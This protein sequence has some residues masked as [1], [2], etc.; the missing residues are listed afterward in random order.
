MKKLLKI[1][2]WVAGIFVVL[3]ILVIVGFKL[4][5]PVEKAKAMAIERA[6]A[7]MGREITIEGID[8]SIWGGLGIQLVEVAVANPPEFEDGKFL[9]ADNVDLKLKFWPLLSG[10]FRIDRLI[11]N[12]PEV[13]MHK[14]ADGSNNYEFKA[15][16][17]AAPPEITEQL[18]PEAKTAGVAVSF[19][20]FEIA[21]G[22]VEFVDDSSEFAVKLVGLDL[23]TTVSNPG[24]GQYL[25]TG[26]LRADSL[27][28]T[29]KTPL[30][31]LAINL[32][33]DAEYDLNKSF[34]NLKSADLKL[35]KLLLKLKG[36]LSHPK[37]AMTVRGNIKSDRIAV[38]D[39]FEFL[40]PK[41]L[42]LVKD[43]RIEGSFALNTDVDYNENRPE[44][45]GYAGTATVTNLKLSQKDIA[46]ELQFEKALIDFKPNNL[47]LNIEKGT[48]DSKPLKGH[49]V[50]ENFA[51]PYVNGELAGSLN[52]AFVQPFLPENMS[53]KITGQ[54]EVDLKVT[55]RTKDYENLDFSG[56]L[57][58]TGG[59]YNSP[60]MPEPLD[61]FNL[62]AYLDRKTTRINKMSGT[63][64]SGSFSFTGRI[65]DLMPYVMADSI[66]AKKIFPGIDG[67]FD[68]KLDLALLTR[69]L[70]PKGNPQLKG[71]MAI[72]LNLLGTIQKP[73][74]IIKRGEI[75][76]ADASYNDSLLPEPLT[77]L[78]AVMKIAPDTIT[79]EKLSAKFVSS[80]ATFSGKLIEPFPYLLPMKNLDRSKL[81]KPMFLFELRSQHFDIDK[82][83]PEATPG[84]GTNRAVAAPDSVSMIILPDIDGKGTFKI[85]TVVYSQ[86]EF[87]EVVGKAKI[88]DRKIE[89]YDV[90]TNVY[91]GK[92]SGS[93]IIDLN[94]FE[95]PRYTGSFDANQI[96]ADDFVSRFS[97]FGGL[98]Y[99]KFNFKGDYSASGWEPEEFMNSLSV[100]SAADM[101]SGKLVT[102]GAVYSTLSS[103]AGKVGDSFDKE[104]ALKDVSTAI[105]VQ[106]GKV[107]LDQMTSS[108]GNVGDVSMDGFYSF[109]GDI[110]YTGSILLSKDQTQKLLSKGSLLGGLAG[111]LSDKSVDRIRLPLKV[112]GTIDKPK[113]D[114]DFSALSKD[115]G[116]NATEEAGNFL[117]GLLKKKK[118]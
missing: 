40:T 29:T 90:T 41:Q 115:V 50:V 71:R 104:Q 72:N 33:Y 58:I 54:A 87:T 30:P 27:F 74:R 62:D 49:M 6:S 81:K 9:S 117:K 25:S 18:T 75:T 19:D 46:G 57:V 45:L 92:A 22:W 106:D 38:A 51:D 1:L 102:S 53:A 98:I 114:I 44:P 39:L 59:S 48:F 52:L 55:G 60:Q 4:F 110:S 2:A 32:N 95:N 8:L 116:K 28:A 34:L 23:S 111:I 97:K 85:D 5:F 65:S 113:V 35:N 10:K 78:E 88:Y 91:S 63:M 103:L 99:G 108:L 100:T 13:H 79:I 89:C 12:S 94:D 36:E 15:L 26:Q 56:H 84:S 82:L 3:L 80:D 67:T 70:P 93:T 11:I 37:G 105:K 17:A 96:E 118:D 42:E 20:R 16:E 64:K 101:K 43:Y 109:A 77:K 66:K 7:K 31:P 47:R 68:G 24:E 14:R 61:T 76:V 83:F 86:V 69:Y 107:M 21:D 73:E 112:S